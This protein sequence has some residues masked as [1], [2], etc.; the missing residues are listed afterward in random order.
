[1]R[2]LCDDRGELPGAQQR[3]GRHRDT[4]R[5][6]HRQ[7]GGDHHRRVR[8]AQQHA[9]A[10]DHAELPRQH[11]GDAVHAR[12]QVSVGPRLGRRPQAR[13]CAVAGRNLPIQQCRDAIELIRVVQSVEQQVRP[14]FAW[15]QIVARE[16]VAKGRG[17]P[18]CHGPSTAVASISTS[19]SVLD[20]A[21]HADHRHGRKVLAHDAAI[22][23]GRSPSLRLDTC[24]MSVTNQVNRTMAVGSAPLRRGC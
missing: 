24:F 4:A 6:D 15:R 7:I 13:T 3:H 8:C 11:I 1:M 22:D 16:V 20:Q 18:G 14:L 21:V 19:A 10:G 9:V 5:L 17:R 12:V 2:A 23:L